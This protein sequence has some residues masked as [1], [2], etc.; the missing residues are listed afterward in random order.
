MEAV[1]QEDRFGCAVACVAMVLGRPYAAVRAALGEVGRGSTHDVWGELLIRESYA[2][3]HLYRVDQ[4]ARGP[5]PAWPLAP[6]APMHLCAVDA[7]GPGALL[8]I[9]LANGAV[10]DPATSTLGRLSD[11]RSVISMTGLYRVDAAPAGLMP[12]A[13]AS[14]STTHV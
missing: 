8:V 14:A 11:Y 10:M 5:R 4:V 9:M 12:G 3:Q 7:G 2:L 6:W 13:S 1:R